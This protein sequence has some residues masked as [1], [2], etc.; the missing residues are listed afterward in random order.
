MSYQ[1]LPVC[2]RWHTYSETQLAFLSL[3]SSLDCSCAYLCDIVELSEGRQQHRDKKN[4]SSEPPLGSAFQSDSDGTMMFTQLV[5][6]SHPENVVGRMEVVKPNLAS[7][8]CY[9]LTPLEVGPRP[10]SHGNFK[11][12]ANRLW[13][14]SGLQRRSG[15]ADYLHLGGQ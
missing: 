5:P 11:R 3:S 6:R 7:T 4:F 8:L 1:G 15:A 9:Q 2:Q 12:A 10:A 13:W 14:L